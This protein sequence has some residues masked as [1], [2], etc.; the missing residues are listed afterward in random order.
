[1]KAKRNA[2]LPWIWMD[3]ASYNLDNDNRG[4]ENGVVKPKF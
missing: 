4:T 1:M 2:K 3:S